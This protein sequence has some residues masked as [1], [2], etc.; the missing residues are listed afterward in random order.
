MGWGRCG[1]VKH[2]CAF[3]DTSLR[4]G[5]L[6]WA[7]SQ[8]TQVLVLHLPTPTGPNPS[9]VNPQSQICLFNSD[10]A[11]APW[12]WG[13]GQGRQWERSFLGFLLDFRKPSGTRIP[14]TS[15]DHF[16]GGACSK[17]SLLFGMHFRTT[18]HAPPF[19]LQDSF[20]TVHLINISLPAPAPTT[21]VPG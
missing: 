5:V 2:H 10:L 15:G 1:K 8:G 16:G 17:N 9:A 4:G 21:G 13:R 14:S 11:S 7:A 3:I 6:L 12:R 18:Q 19:S 20:F